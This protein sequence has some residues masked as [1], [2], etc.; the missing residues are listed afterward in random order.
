MLNKLVTKWYMV[1]NLHSKTAHRRHN[2]HIIC[3]QGQGFPCMTNRA[4]VAGDIYTPVSEQRVRINL[5]LKAFYNT[6]FLVPLPY[7][8][9]ETAC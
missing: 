3:E 2:L 9:S 7:N 4:L 1:S 8:I 5:K 6:F